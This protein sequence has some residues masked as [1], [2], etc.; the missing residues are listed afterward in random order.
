[1]NAHSD[2]WGAHAPSRAGE[3]ALAI[4]DFS[5]LPSLTSQ[6]FGEGAEM[7]TRGGCAPQ[8]YAFAL[9]ASSLPNWI[10]C[11]RGS[12]VEKLIVFVWRRI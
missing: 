10:P 11:A 9:P 5:F 6:P 12:S 1:M 8:T 7:S 4:A 3:G 2:F